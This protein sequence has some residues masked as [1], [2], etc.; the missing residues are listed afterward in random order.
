MLYLH[1]F[2]HFKK[3]KFNFC[4]KTASFQAKTTQTLVLNLY[5]MVLK[6]SRLLQS[7]LQNHMA[8]KIKRGNKFATNL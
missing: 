2:F 3:F 7:E 1:I 8:K 5:C 4:G 6:F